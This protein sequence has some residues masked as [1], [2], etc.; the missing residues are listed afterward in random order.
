MKPQTTARQAPL[1][2]TISRGLLKFMSIEWV[3]LSNHLILCHPLLP[4]PSIFPS[5][6]VFSNESALLIR[7]P[8]HW[9]FSFNNTREVPQILI[10]SLKHSH[11]LCFTEGGTEAQRGLVT[12]LGI[13]QKGSGRACS[14]P[15]SCAVSKCAPLLP[16][17]GTWI[18]GG[19]RAEASGSPSAVQRVIPALFSPIPSVSRLT[20]GPDSLSVLAVLVS[21]EL[22]SW[23]LLLYRERCQEDAASGTQPTPVCPGSAHSALCPAEAGPDLCNLNF[24]L[25]QFLP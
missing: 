1:S 18:P 15:L 16:R 17:R 21:V 2:F 20:W 24:F 25:A 11:D 12:Y 3:M 6:R 5:I 14:S 13:T 4:L 8:M 9:S 23:V 7:W 22:A 10:S 19:R